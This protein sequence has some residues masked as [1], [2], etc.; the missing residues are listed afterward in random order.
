M[1][2]DLSSLTSVLG[3]GI[4]LVL[5]LLALWGLFCAVVVWLRVAQC[6]FRNE[7]TQNEFLSE[8]EQAISR[9]D[10]AGA[11]ALCE[12]DRRAMPQL[13]LMAI[14]QRDLG[15]AKLRQMVVD[16]FQRDFLADLEFR[17]SWV[18]TVIK[19]APMIGLLGTVVGMMGAFAKIAGESKGGV[20]PA[21]LAG[22]I[23]LALMTTACGLAIAIPLVL[24]TASINVRIRKMEDLVAGGL[25]RFFEGLRVAL[26]K[27]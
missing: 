10:F 26:A 7:K 18:Q 4:Y 19:S 27:Q 16:R 9:G 2:I 25:T 15:Y 24:C 20:E 11:A 1:N 17:L 8:L 6:R 22:D 14:S 21:M 23:S 3:T 12:H 5:A 13:A